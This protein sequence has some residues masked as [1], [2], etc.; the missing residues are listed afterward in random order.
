MEEIGKVR[1]IEGQRALVEIRPTSLC[2]S[3]QQKGGCA[4][5]SSGVKV[6]EAKNFIQAKEGDLVKVA[7]ESN[8][9]ILSSLILFGLPVLFLIL[10]VIFGISVMKGIYSHP[11]RHSQ[12]YP[13]IFGLCGFILAFLIL[14]VLNNLFIRR[15]FFLP[16]VVKI[17]KGGNL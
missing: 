4:I 17:E 14:R 5:F 7:L 1:K 3:C 16:K 15:G 8:K 12:I 9:E 11:N 13:F 6:I 10:G 2:G